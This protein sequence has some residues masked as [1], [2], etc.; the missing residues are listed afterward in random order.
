MNANSYHSKVRMFAILIMVAV[1]PAFAHPGSGIQVLENGDVYFVDTGHGIWHID[2]DGKVG[3]LARA[4][5]HFLAV[6]A[7]SAYSQKHFKQLERGDV[8]VISEK[9]DVMIGTS[10]PITV[11]SDGASYY[12]QVLSKGRVKM[13][14][15][16]PGKKAQQ[17]AVLPPARERSYTGE[18]VD[19][20]WVWAIAP[21][22]KCSIYYT[23]KRAVRRIDSDGAVHTVAENVTVPGCERPPA[24]TESHVEPGLYGLCVA[25]DGTVYVAASACSA[26]LKI[27][28]GGTQSVALRATDGWSPQGVAINRNTLY[29]LEYNYVKAGDR[30]DWLPRVRKVDAAGIATV[31]AQINKPARTAAVAKK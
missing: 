21:G 15:M 10:Y 23:E 8:E 19:A 26:L 25:N 17:F 2:T 11:S 4:D 18:W 12:P 6:D 31:I 20:E 30:A 14:R 9:P 13:M 3:S 27:A 1:V 29:V 16:L 22:T 5:G 7:S 24:V 28:P